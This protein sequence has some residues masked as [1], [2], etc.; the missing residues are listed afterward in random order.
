MIND[1][2]DADKAEAETKAEDSSGVG[3]EGRGRDGL[4]L[5]DD[6]VV[7]IFEENFQNRKILF[8]VFDQKTG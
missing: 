2:K 1:F 7:R 8:G 6:R 3:D 5:L 4:V